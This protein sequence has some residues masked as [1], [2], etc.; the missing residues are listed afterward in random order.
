MVSSGERVEA[1]SASSISDMHGAS[2]K[3][4]A[5]QHAVEILNPQLPTH[6]Q[7]AS[8]DARGSD[9]EFSVSQFSASSSAPLLTPP[10]FR[11]TEM[12]GSK[13]SMGGA[14]TLGESDTLDGASAKSG[15]QEE[16]PAHTG[17]TSLPPL[18]MQPQHSASARIPDDTISLDPTDMSGA[19]G[20]NGVADDSC[21]APPF[22]KCACMCLQGSIILQYRYIMSA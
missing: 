22:I 10:P 18:L 11:G 20:D 16:A 8:T 5:G 3:I 14:D 13:G 17:Q 6:N 7:A 12:H 9:M 15:C 19:A 4:Q 2:P 1:E 21:A